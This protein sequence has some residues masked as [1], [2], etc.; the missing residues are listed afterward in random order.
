VEP[1]SVKWKQP[2]S[3]CALLLT[4]F[5]PVSRKPER[6]DQRAADLVRRPSSAAT[7]ARTTRK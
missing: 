3:F 5:R 1:L 7:G 4:A 2:L 6:E